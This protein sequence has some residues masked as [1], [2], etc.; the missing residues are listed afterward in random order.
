M[1]QATVEQVV[2]W[3]R[4][5]L[6]DAQRKERGVA[7]A[8]PG[9]VLI[10]DVW[11]PSEHS[12]DLAVDLAREGFAVLE[13]D[14]YRELRRREDFRIEAPGPFIL[15]LSDP[16]ILEDLD[17]AGRWLCTQAG[18]DR[19]VGVMGVCMGGTYALLAACQSEVFAA[20]APFYGILSYDHGLISSPAERDLAR[21]P[22]SPIEAAPRLRMPLLAAF[23]SE[24]GFVPE[25]DVRLLDRALAESGVPH[26]TRIHEGAGHAFLN[27]TRPEAYHAKAAEA[28][29][30]SLIPFLH[31]QLDSD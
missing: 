20:S 3:G 27:R 18:A 25:S 12:H 23:G 15:G 5:H 4:L 29:W 9:V 21:K 13:I 19:R 24:D 8:D 11:G 2:S 28:A 30:G 7:A 14:L 22:L 16:E 6:R 10:H 1:S 26:E 17:D 31:D